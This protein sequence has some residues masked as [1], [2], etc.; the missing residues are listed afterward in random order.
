MKQCLLS[1]TFLFAALSAFAVPVKRGCWQ[2]LTLADGTEVRAEL[3]GD[4]HCRWWQDADGTR[5]VADGVDGA[6]VAVGRDALPSQA[7][8]RKAR[9]VRRV[10]ER[11]M[12]RAAEGAALFQGRRKG[13]IILAE[14][15]NCKFTKGNQAMVW[16]MA[17]E[18]GFSK[19]GA[20][21]SVADYFAEQSGGQFTLDFDVAGPVTMSHNYS[22]YGK[23]DEENAPEMI[24][25]ACIGVD[26]SINFA[27]YD[28]DG[29][30]VAEEVFVL[31][32]GHGQADYDSKNDNLIWQ[33][34][35]SVNPTGD[36]DSVFVLDG[37]VIDVYACSSELDGSGGLAGIGTF[38]HEFSHCMGLPDM[39]DTGESGNFGMGSWDLMDYGSY[40]G[41]GHVPVG[42]SGYEKMVCGWTT[43][44]ELD[45]E[46]K[47]EGVRPLADMGQSYIVYNQGNRNEYYILENRQ[48]KGFDASLPGHGLLIE[49]VDYDKTLWDYNVVNTTDDADIPNN[50]QRI[51]IFHAN[52]RLTNVNAAYPYNGND[53][54]T[55]TSRP[56]ATVYNANADGSLFMG[57]AIRGITENAD[58]TMS[59]TF[60]AD[61][62]A[63]PDIPSDG[64]LFK[65]TFDLCDGTGGNDGKFSGIRYGHE[66]N[67]DNDGWESYGMM[68][69]GD[70]C[71]WFGTSKERGSVITPSFTLTGDTA[72]LSFRAAGWDASG[73]G[74]WLCVAV[75]EGSARL[76]GDGGRE[77]IV[78]LTMEKGAW[79]DYT[80]RI[81]GSGSV[82]L[83][84]YAAKRFFLDDVVVSVEGRAKNGIVAPRVSAGK[85][86][87]R[88]YTLGG[89]FVGTDITRLPKG[90]YIMGGR[91]VVR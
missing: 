19:N 2:T 51:T 69:G 87:R 1:L 13:L 91:K 50:H 6:F 29:D 89:Q 7:G 53:S 75:E 60:A 68:S 33:H 15:P 47:V 64:V 36:P 35:Y 81:V 26:G 9:A 58:S 42:Y 10:R 44:V 52:N 28:W 30:G 14:F 45:G 8:L 65:E 27:D 77:E 85:A 61:S 40:S 21:G 12:R 73:D 16:R 23:D 90:I 43:P 86:S 63:T 4:E 88:V 41:N 46:G 39:Y 67:P 54:L 83:Q 25:E 20:K 66:F 5:Y 57:C 3:R 49:H 82:R 79:H 59:F 84:F 22:Y 18:H 24:K 74:T 37:T 38:C 76:V 31:Y 17:N 34:M 71:A 80:L 32:A 11:V 78:E 72:T 48:R 55:S 62:A 56:A 70:R